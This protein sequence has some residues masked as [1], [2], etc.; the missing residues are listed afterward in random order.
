MS[1]WTADEIKE[2]ADALHALSQSET[3][4]VTELWRNRNTFDCAARLDRLVRE[5]VEQHAVGVVIGELE[6]R[7]PTPFA[8]DVFTRI[9]RILTDGPAA[10]WRWHLSQL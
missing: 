2:M 6:H 7:A 1:N 10:E 4:G 5:G 8:H 3:A 9:A